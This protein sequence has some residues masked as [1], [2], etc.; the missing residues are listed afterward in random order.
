MAARHGPLALVELLIRR[1][2]IWWVQDSRGQEPLDYARS[3]VAPD[4]AEIV[5]LLDRPVIRDAQFRAAVGAIHRGDAAGLAR[6]LDAHPRLLRER[7]IEPDCY[8]PSY[9]RDPRLFW[10]VANNPYLVKAQPPN[11][12]EIAQ[13][14]VA[15]GV[16]K[17]DLDYTLELVMSNGNGPDRANQLP[18]MNALVS[19]G[20]TPTTRAL[21]MALGHRETRPVEAL[22]ARGLALTASIAAALGRNRELAALL[23]NAAADERQKALGMAVINRQR[24][25]ARLCLDAGA[26]VNGFLPVHVHSTP[27]HQAVANEDRPMMELLLARGARADIP[28]TMWNSTALGW[29][30]FMQKH[31]AEAVLTAARDA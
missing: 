21:D 11:I 24:E 3:G 1:G 25:A 9:F 20:A 28:D 22:L 5:A 8:P 7:A 10:F 30:K 31:E 2:A 16:E 14:M 19:A 6:L 13:T 15:R 12:V 4:K 29:A 27:L 18:L 23:P 17:A 26:D